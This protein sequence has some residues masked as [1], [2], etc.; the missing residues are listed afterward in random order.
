M[1]EKIASDESKIVSEG[2]AVAAEEVS[3]NFE[4]HP[5]ENEQLPRHHHSR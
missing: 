2:Q 1:E 3:E 5:E 4:K